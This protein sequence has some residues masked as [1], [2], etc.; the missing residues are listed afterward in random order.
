MPSRRLAALVLLAGAPL[1]SQALKPGLALIPASVETVEIYPRP[2][3]AELRGRA[4]SARFGDAGP[5]SGLEGRTGLR[6]AELSPGAAFLAEYP[7]PEV[8]GT[9]AKQA[10]PARARYLA[11][12]PAPAPEALLTRLKATRHGEFWTYTL[13]GETRY[14]VAR[15]GFL[16]ISADRATLQSALAVKETLA[17]EVD[18]PLE[19]WLASHDTDLLWSGRTLRSGLDGAVADLHKPAAAPDPGLAWKIR[20]RALVEKARASVVHAALGLDLAQDGSVRMSVK[21]FYRPGSPLAVDAAALAPLGTHPLAGLAEGPFALAMGGQWPDWFS[22][23]GSDPD[24]AQA[25]YPA[26]S[27]PTGFQVRMAQALQAEQAQV[28]ALSVRVAPPAQA[29]DPLLKG[30]V[31]VLRVS[32][33]SAYLAAQDRVVALHTEAAAKSGLAP[34]LTLQKAILPD[35]PSYALVTDLTRL[36]GGQAQAAMVGGF[37]FGEPRMRQS[38]AKVDEHTLV[39]VFGDAEALQRTLQAFKRA[40]ALSAAPGIKRTDT[41]LPPDS[42]FTL[43]LDLKGL[44]DLA[45]ALASAFGKGGAPL[46]EVPAVAPLGLA[47]T[48]DPS[49]FQLQGAAHPETLAALSDLFAQLRKATAQAPDATPEPGQE[50]APEGKEPGGEP[51]PEPDAD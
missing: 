1:L 35:V 17:K 27:L 31:S 34:L 47:F 30:A 11:V 15:G 23:M 18:A 13:A 14:A 45:Q 39:S 42:R 2:A 6:P 24:L 51:A 41:L 49:G 10:A 28:Q 12:V 16:L 44:R 3:E 19:A 29:G 7:A 33:A 26:G 36:Q 40:G 50:A 37:L 8:Q 43:Y 48:C 4:F 46:P 9:P 22:L 20:F 38:V 32:D 21:A 25:A 5:F